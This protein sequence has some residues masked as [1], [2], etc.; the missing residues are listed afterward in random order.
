MGVRSLGWE[1]P[2]EGIATHSSILVWRTPWAEE[3]GGLQSVGF[4]SQTPLSTHT[5]LRVPFRGPMAGFHPSICVDQ[6][7]QG[8]EE[9][10]RT[11]SLTEASG[12]ARSQ[13]RV[14]PA[15]HMLPT[16]GGDGKRRTVHT[17]QLTPRVESGQTHRGGRRPPDQLGWAD[18]H[19][20]IRLPSPLT[21]QCRVL[22]WER[23]VRASCPGSNVTDNRPGC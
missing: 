8:K 1:D 14:G 22:P 18:T 21:T 2:L 10:A 23:S 17:N 5:L 20:H 9:V 7:K 3:P 13:A 19:S 4:Q 11:G 6:S 16:G 15:T 12:E